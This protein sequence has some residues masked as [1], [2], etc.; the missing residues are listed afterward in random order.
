MPT[1]VKS[2]KSSTKKVDRPF[3]VNIRLTA[4][5]KLRLEEAARARGFGGVSDFVRSMSSSGLK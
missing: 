2:K 5:E 1:S 3:E 4:V